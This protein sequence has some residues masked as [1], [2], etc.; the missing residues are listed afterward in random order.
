MAL[1]APQYGDLVKFKEATS[2]FKDKIKLTSESYK[3]L[4]GLVH[5]KA[6]TVAGATQIEIINELYKAVDKAISDGE[7]I[8]DFRKRFD[9]VVDDHGWSYNGKRGWR[10][11]VIYQNNKNTAR[12]AGRWQQQERLKQ[13]RPYLLY[14]TAGDSRVRPEHGKWN[15]ILLPVD[16]PFWDTHYPPNGYNCRC[17]VVSLNARDIARMGLSVTKPEK[18]NKFMESFKVVDP[19]TGEELNKLAG[20]DL[21]WDYNPGKAW[22]GADIAA[23]KSVMTLSTDI[24]KLAVPQ[25]NEAVLKSQQ[26]YIKQVNLQAAKLAL[27]KSVPDSQQFTLG[28]LPVNLLNELSRKNAPIYSS[29]VTVSSAQIEKFLTGKLA[30]EQVHELMNAV[31]NPNT[32]AYIGNQV[33]ISYQGFMITVELGPTFNT[34]IAAEKV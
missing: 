30:I 34:I 2:H 19:S 3:D 17:K 10:T 28:H 8:S 5:A 20:I 1:P 12:A 31:Q 21:G 25:F 9:K 22:L 6:F 15:Y 11:K 27:K 33:K 14:L 26:Y 4:Q 7:T 18:V 32:F 29:A 13:R 23:G 24:Q 16:H